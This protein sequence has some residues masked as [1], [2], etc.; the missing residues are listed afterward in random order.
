MKRYFIFCDECLNS[1]ELNVYML[2][3]LKDDKLTIIASDQFRAFDMNFRAARKR[4][5]IEEW[6]FKYSISGNIQEV[7][8]KKPLIWL[9][10]EKFKNPLK[11][12]Y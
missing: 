12:Y 9:T 6:R 5:M 4:D 10:R 11:R 3:M 8:D 1:Q 7:D 2:A